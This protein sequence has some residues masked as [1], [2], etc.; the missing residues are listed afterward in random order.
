MGG[1]PDILYYALTLGEYF[2]T[3][4]YEGP[5]KLNISAQ[6]LIGAK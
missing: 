4:K 6:L 5:E 1:V 2:C 3:S